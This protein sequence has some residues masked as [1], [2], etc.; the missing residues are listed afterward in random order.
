MKHTDQ[1]RRRYSFA[2]DIPQHDGKPAGFRFEY[3]VEV[4]PDLVGCNRARCELQILGY[5]VRLRFKVTL[6]TPGQLQFAL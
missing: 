5:G 3:V 6:N 2:R 4:S 1:Q